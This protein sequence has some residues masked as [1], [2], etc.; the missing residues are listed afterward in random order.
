MIGAMPPPPL[1]R[2]LRALPVESVNDYRRPGW[3]MAVGV[4]S[5]C[6]AAALILFH[7]FAASLAFT[8]RIQNQ[9]TQTIFASPAYAPQAVVTGDAGLPKDEVDAAVDGLTRVRPLSDPRAAAVRRLIKQHGRAMFRFTPITAA[10]AAGVSDSGQMFDNGGAPADYF[11]L[12]EGR[13]EVDDDGAV[14][15]PDGGEALRSGPETEGTSLTAEQAEAFVANVAAQI[16]GAIPPAVR[17]GLK[18]ALQD[19]QQTLV[20]ATASIEVIDAQFDGASGLSVTPAAGVYFRTDFNGAVIAVGG[21]A[22]LVIPPPPPGGRAHAAAGWLTLL[23]LL[24]LG[25]AILL[26]AGSIFWLNGRPVARRLMLLFVVISVPLAVATG[27]VLGMTAGAMGRLTGTE[28]FQ[29]V[30]AVV[31]GATLLAWPLVLGMVLFTTPVK[32]Y[33]ARGARVLR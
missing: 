30:T 5:I 33:F 20:N 27:A 1:P 21:A 16:D 15:R 25:V 17:D 19:P 10:R 26:I 22:P 12:P 13:L 24:G 2:P 8:V 3:I 23:S 31:A 11:V 7:L 9:V 4:I 29:P 32:T 18:K 6:V 14:Y 28:E